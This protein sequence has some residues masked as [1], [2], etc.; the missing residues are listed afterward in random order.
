MEIVRVEPTLS[1]NTMKIVL[2]FKKEDRSSNTYTEVNDHNPEF[3]NRIL[4]LDGI[5]SVFHVMDFIAV[6]KR[7]KENW[8]TLLKD[9]TAAISGSDQEGDFAEKK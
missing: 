9:V 3:I 4:Q 2:S 6:D 7:P 8:D 1:P 5:K